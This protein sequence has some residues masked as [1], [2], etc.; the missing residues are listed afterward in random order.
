P[1]T[2]RN[3]RRWKSLLCQ[4]LGMY[5]HDERF[6]VIAAIEN[7][8]VPL[9]GQA[10]HAAPEKIVVEVFGRRRL[11]GKNLAALRVH[12]RQDVLDS[13]ILSGGVHGLKNQQQSPFVLRVKLVL[14]LRQRL[15]A[16]G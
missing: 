11:E 1:N 8:E 16:G 14:Q 5:T 15:N 13:A 12:A 4:K 3:Q 2:F 9:V 10:L 6:L 7:A